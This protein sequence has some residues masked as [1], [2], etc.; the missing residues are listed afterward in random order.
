M[1]IA[2]IHPTPPSLNCIVAMI[3]RAFWRNA[4]Y[5]DKKPL[6]AAEKPES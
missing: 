2:G 4:I 1:Q 5:L 6:D 3:V